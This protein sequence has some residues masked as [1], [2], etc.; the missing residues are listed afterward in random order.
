VGPTVFDLLRQPT[1]DSTPCFCAHHILFNR[2]NHR[3]F[4]A[5]LPASGS[6]RASILDFP[7]ISHGLGLHMSSQWPG[8]GVLQ[9]FIW[10]YFLTISSPECGLR[11]HRL[12][13]YSL[14]HYIIVSDV[15][16]ISIQT[17]Y[18]W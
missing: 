14:H 17:F 16:N 7:G 15:M 11:E 5:G 4:P 18:R 2:G 6:L 13:W 10:P 1:Q 9:I 12:C 3:Q 8:Y